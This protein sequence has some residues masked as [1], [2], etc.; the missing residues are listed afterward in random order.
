[1]S[2]TDAY[3]QCFD[4]ALKN[5]ERNG[6]TI[7]T[8]S[9]SIKVQKP[10]TVRLEQGFTGMKPCLLAEG[11]EHLGSSQSS[12][13]I[14]EFDG[15]GITIYGNISC[16]DKTYEAQLEVIVDGRTDRVMKLCSDFNKRTADCLYWNYDLPEGHHQV[17]F[18]LLNPHED[19]NIKAWRIIKYGL[20]IEE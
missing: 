10:K 7:G 2:L 6:G 3:R 12:Q 16:P 9:I 14:F 8:D 19:A 18:R 1:M 20:G 11:I 15:T 5:I 17:R 4:L 13:N